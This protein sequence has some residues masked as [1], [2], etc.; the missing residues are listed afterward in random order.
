[1]TGI[2]SAG[3]G[4]GLD[5]AGL[6]TKLVAVEND[7]ATKRL[8]TKEAGVQAKVSGLGTF[9]GALSSFQSSLSGLKYLSSFQKV[10]ATSSDTTT[11]GA[12]AVSSA[13]AGNYQLNV[14]QL[15]QS[16]GLA[17]KAYATASDVV[18]TG[19]LTIKFGTTA[20]DNAGVPTGFSQNAAKGTLTLSVNPTNNTLTGLRDAINSKNAGVSAAIVN[21]GTGNRLV[22]SSSDSGAK[23]SL[24]VSVAGDAGLSA[25]AYNATT[26]NLAQTQSAQD[27]QVTING[28]NVSSDSNT[29][30]SALKGVTLNLQKVGK[31]SLAVGQDNSNISTAIDA[32]VKGYNDLSKTVTDLSSYDPKAQTVGVLIGDSTLKSAVSR[33]RSQMSGVVSGLGNSTFRSL[34]D[35]GISTQADGT[36]GVDSAKL[37]SALSSNRNAVAALFAV[38][39]RPSDTGVSY[40]GSTANTLVG[41]FAVNVSA[42]ATQGVL[43]GSAIG[44]LPLIVNSNNDIFRVSI[45]GVSSGDLVLSPKPSPGYTGAELAAEIQSRINGDSALKTAG[46]SAT[47]SYDSAH[48]W[49][50][51]QSS[52]FGSSSKVAISQVNA[53]SSV[54]LGLTLGSGTDGVDIAGTINGGAATGDGQTLTATGGS[55]QGLALTIADSTIGSRGTVV[56]SRGLMESMDST[57]NSFLASKTGILSARQDGM[58]HSLKSISDQRAALATRMSAL[59]TRLSKQ[60]N[61]MDALVGS[62]QSTGSA[63]T[64]QFASLSKL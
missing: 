64:Q 54:D 37:N 56:F 46:I 23:N 12:S 20:F 50:V 11:V 10:N 25:L 60:F 52:S 45:N 31:A 22:L 48:N 34:V 8:D 57:L 26:H 28:L 33:L 40:S 61:A 9:K 30:S 13:E 49:L 2:T 36:L 58:Q 35:I 47:T 27:A 51:F 5:I 53:T 7:P 14:T 16:Q 18:G 4:S 15:A 41:N 44:T 43:H 38:V 59:Q 21:D 63:L 29:L 62:L 6:V 24:E 17:S 55:A 3:L 32:F 42:S 39:G 19:T 1:M